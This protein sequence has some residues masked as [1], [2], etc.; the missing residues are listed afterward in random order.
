[1]SKVS[2]NPKRKPQFNLGDIV[3][4]SVTTLLVTDTYAG[5]I[6]V[7]SE[8]EFAGV[9]LHSYTPEYSS[10][11]LHVGEKARFSCYNGTIIINSD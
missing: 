7:D 5:D 9:I 2:L 10:G 4:D 8:K 11:E 3:T 1:M 6:E